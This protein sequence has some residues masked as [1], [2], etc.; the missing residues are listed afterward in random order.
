MDEWETVWP[1]DG[2]H[3]KPGLLQ[4]LHSR[5]DAQLTVLNRNQG[6]LNAAARLELFGRQRTGFLLWTR[7]TVTG[8][9][10]LRAVERDGYHVYFKGTLSVRPLTDV[11]ETTYPIRFRLAPDPMDQHRLVFA[12]VVE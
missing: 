9:W 11:L 1:K 8:Q 7:N 5:A 6:Y 3:G 4:R 12:G 2:A 10:G